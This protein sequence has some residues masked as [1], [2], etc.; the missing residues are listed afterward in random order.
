[1][2]VLALDPLNPQVAARLVGPFNRWK[3]YD[4]QRQTRMVAELERI[5]KTPRLSK[6]VL[7]VVTKALG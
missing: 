3:K 7:E 6:D 2:Q 5:R 1:N 4:D